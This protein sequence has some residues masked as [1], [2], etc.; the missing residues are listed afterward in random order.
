VSAEDD[1]IGVM[2]GLG[3]CGFDV[4]GHEEDEEEAHVPHLAAQLRMLYRVLAIKAPDGH[5]TFLVCKFKGGFHPMTHWVFRCLKRAFAGVGV[6]RPIQSRPAN[7]ER[8]VV[9]CGKKTNADAVKAMDELEQYLQ[10]VES[11]F[12]TASTLGQRIA[13]L[14]RLHAAHLTAVFT[15]ATDNK[16]EL[17]RFAEWC[18]YIAVHFSKQQLV[19]LQTLHHALELSRTLPRNQTLRAENVRFMVPAEFLK[20][21]PVQPDVKNS[22]EELDFSYQPPPPSDLTQ[23]DIARFWV[24]VADTI[25]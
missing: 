21:P 2:I 15:T 12:K 20:P 25:K 22:N 9:A 14:K 13:V 6:I 8:Y 11:E 16:E 7:S 19:G 24:P 1:K 18:R 5:E 17:Q 3:D 23:K 4:Q 10:V